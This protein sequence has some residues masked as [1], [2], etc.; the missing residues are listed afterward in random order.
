VARIITAFAT[1]NK[2][3]IDIVKKSSKGLGGRNRRVI[4]D[5]ASSSRLGEVGTKSG[6]HR[7]CRDGCCNLQK[8]YFKKF[9]PASKLSAGTGVSWP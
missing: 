4:L 6:E 8:A 7:D 2:F 9:Q 3:N 5:L 1:E